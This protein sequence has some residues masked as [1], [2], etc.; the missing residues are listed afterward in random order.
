MKSLEVET[1]LEFGVSFD[2]LSILLGGGWG[3]TKDEREK[4]SMGKYT[5]VLVK[6][7]C[8]VRY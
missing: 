2:S 7:D 1:K 8:G 5:P 4:Q 3:S 6:M